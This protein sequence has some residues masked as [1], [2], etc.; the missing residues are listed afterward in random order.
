MSERDEQTG[1]G[2]TDDGQ[3]TDQPSTE[4]SPESA[5]DGANLE[6][7]SATSE[8][9][10]A[11][12]TLASGTEEAQAERPVDDS[13]D[14]EIVSLPRVKGKPGRKPFAGGT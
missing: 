2:R 7:N 3:L 4:D 9:T 10:T 13:D 11:E 12:S 1:T 5:D 14:V 6:D 8:S